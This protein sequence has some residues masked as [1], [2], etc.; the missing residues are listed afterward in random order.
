M[1]RAAGERPLLSALL[2]TSSQLEPVPISAIMRAGLRL[3][4][5]TA[6]GLLSAARALTERGH[7]A[8]LSAWCEYLRH[9]EANRTDE[10]I[11]R[12]R[13][14]SRDPAV[15]QLLTV[16]LKTA[17]GGD[18]GAPQATGGPP[19]DPDQP[20]DPGGPLAGAEHVT[21]FAGAA[22]SMTGLARREL[23]PLLD[24]ALLGHSGVLL[25]GGTAVGM[26]GIIGRIAQRQRLKLIGYVPTGLGDHE[27]YATI[28]ETRGS[29]DFS[30]L[31]PLGMWHDI[32]ISGIDPGRVALIA[33]PGGV[34]TLQEIAL[35][36]AL[37]ARVGWLDPAGEA[38]QPLDELLP[39][40]A[41]GVVEL[42]PDAMTIRAFIAPTMLARAPRAA[43][44]RYS[45]TIIAAASASARATVTRPC[46][47]WEEL[48]ETLRASNLAQADDIPSKL[49]LIGKRAMPG[50]EPLELGPD[51]VELLAEVEHGRWNAE[52]LSTRLA[53]R[54]AP[55]GAEHLA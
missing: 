48:P 6:P 45:T 18:N 46:A 30:V 12:I 22:G 47:R 3:D 29:T 54:T 13:D 10:Q 32:V 17:R 39:L 52:R 4:L 38:S 35:A 31:E 34:I 14:T 1:A 41:A 42:L 28:R 33:C 24:R 26:P 25:S 11:I 44:A 8:A 40:G 7:P 23:E 43:V 36:R 37:G 20:A 49:A 5:D 9:P 15:G 27:L 2:D 16:A 50:G 55:G 21:I 19:A 51:Q 53:G